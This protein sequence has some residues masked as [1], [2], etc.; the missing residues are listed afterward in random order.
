MN[1]CGNEIADEL[2]GEGSLADIHSDGCLTFSV[3]AFHVKQDINALCRVATMWY[4]W[5]ACY[6]PGAALI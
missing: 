4:E 3:I 5:C 2:A 6:C 1:V